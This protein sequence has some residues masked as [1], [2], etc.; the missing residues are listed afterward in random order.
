MATLRDHQVRALDGLRDEVRNGYR[1][2]M[3][4]MP[5]G[6][7]KTE[8]AKQIIVNAT[9]KGKR[10][11]FVV[12]RIEL[13]KQ[14][15]ERLLRYGVDHGVIQAAHRLTDP[16][17]PVQVCSI[18]TLNRRKWNNF[19]I[20]IIDE[21][22][23]AAAPMYKK[24]LGTR[25]SD[26]YLA[27]GL[28]ATPF[29]R[30]L[31]A[32]TPEVKGRLFERL[33]VGATI[34]ELVDAGWLVDVEIYAPSEPDLNGVRTVAGDYDEKQLG[35]RVNKNTLVGDIVAHWKKLAGG[36]QTICF[37][38]NIAHS[39]AIVEQFVSAGVAAEHI[40]TYTPDSQRDEIL[41][42]LRS[43]ETKI[44]SNVAILAEG[45]D[46]PN[47]GCMILARPTKS[48][49]RYIQMV[50]RALRPAEG[51]SHALILDHSG[52]VRRLGW[53]TDDLQVEL[54]DG[55]RRTPSVQFREK[56]PAIC[57][58]CMFVKPPK[59]HECPKCGFAPKKRHGVVTEAGELKKLEKKTYTN[60][61]KQEIY[62]ALIYE[63]EQMKKKRPLTK[64]GWVAHKYKA[65]V[66]VWPR[67]LSWTIGK[68]NDVVTGYL[69]H[70]RIAWRKRKE[71]ELKKKVS[72]PR[73]GSD[74]L[75]M[76]RTSGHM[77]EAECKSCGFGRTQA[78]WLDRS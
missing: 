68:P 40:D 16:D 75:L 66:G 21:A 2:V 30:G 29:T 35:E 6:S 77:R 33:V 62:S 69:I 3:L 56:L 76:K 50:G 60:A 37:A 42:R 25:P 1:R 20:I 47:I 26:A 19:D 52:T 67:G 55:K 34:R 14:T 13:V 36:K 58:S 44:V 7:G 48:L 11:Y 65:I 72:C 15:S 78:W 28:S 43:G 51:K 5:T 74:D 73:C 64:D 31:G 41:G 53:P 9:S 61:Q 24:F 45:F 22:H 39:K 70:E 57:P 4:M 17:K 27:I 10:V 59:V 12:P 49:T 38:T 71:A 18:Q 8:V 46:M 32:Y 63:F 23:G 54:D